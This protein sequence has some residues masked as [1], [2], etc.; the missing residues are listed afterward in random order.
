MFPFRVIIVTLVTFVLFFIEAL[1]H[2]NIGKNGYDKEISLKITF[3]NKKELV[4]IVI[5]LAIFSI[6]NGLISNYLVKVLT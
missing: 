6:I 3:P 2:F 5:I 1:F 4:C